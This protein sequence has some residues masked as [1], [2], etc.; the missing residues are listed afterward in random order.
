MLRWLYHVIFEPLSVWEMIKVQMVF[1]PIFVLAWIL[2]W[3]LIAWRM[4]RKLK[5][6]DNGNG[7]GD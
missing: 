6:K 2:T 7:L 3:S 1:V 5:R 4:A